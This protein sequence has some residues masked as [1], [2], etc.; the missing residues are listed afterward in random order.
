M[1][2]RL[3]RVPW[4]KVRV[5]YVRMAFSRSMDEVGTFSIG[6]VCHL[7]IVIAKNVFTIGS[8]IGSAV[9]TIRQRAQIA[10]LCG[11]TS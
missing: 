11:V 8:L 1:I 2:E 5:V 3:V 4:K 7:V 9:C 6:K 10:S